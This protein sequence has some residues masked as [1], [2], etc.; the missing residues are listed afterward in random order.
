MEL[1]SLYSNSYAVL[2]IESR[3]PQED[4]PA[5]EK[6]KAPQRLRIRFLEVGMRAG[7]L[8]RSDGTIQGV[9]SGGIALHTT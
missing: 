6:R 8:I 9:M 4:V 2:S 3:L 1:H 5:K 7:G